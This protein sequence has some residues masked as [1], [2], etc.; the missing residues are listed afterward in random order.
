VNAIATYLMVQIVWWRSLHH[1]YSCFD[2]RVCAQPAGRLACHQLLPDSLQV[3][4][5]SAEK[6]GALA[7]DVMDALRAE[8]GALES[9]LALAWAPAARAPAAALDPADGAKVLALLLTLP[10]GVVKYSHAVPG[11]G[12]SLGLCLQRRRWSI[13]GP[14]IACTHGARRT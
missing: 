3:P 14:R 1:C 5:E 13:C 9:D 4:A 6:A 10:H 8:Y 12:Q 7:R 11:G 2:I